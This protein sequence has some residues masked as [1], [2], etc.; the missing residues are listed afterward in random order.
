[1]I[2]KS[3]TCPELSNLSSLLQMFAFHIRMISFVTV[4]CF[5]LW[6]AYAVLDSIFSLTHHKKEEGKKKK[7][8]GR[9][10]EEEEREREKERKERENL[11]AYQELRKLS[12]VKFLKKT[13]NQFSFKNKV[14]ITVFGIGRCFPKEPG[15]EQ[16]ST[17][18]FV[19][20]V[21][22]SGHT[23]LGSSPFP[24]LSMDPTSRPSL[25]S[26]LEQKLTMRHWLSWLSPL[27]QLSRI[28]IN[29]SLYL[30]LPELRKPAGRPEV[31][32]F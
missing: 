21:V 5:H 17:S 19:Q 27:F 23:S 7:G 28:E 14:N 3:I 2:L 20:T 9:R 29:V 13:L 6:P 15:K 10:E 16:I 8:G 24:A 12:L 25:V 26:G 30:L 32:T 11:K 31:A 1:M 18:S 4:I 22:S